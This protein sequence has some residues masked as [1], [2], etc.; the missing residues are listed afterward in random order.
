MKFIFS[1]DQALL[2]KFLDEVQGKIAEAKAGA[3]QDSARE[4]VREGRANIAAA[5]FSTRWQQGLRSQFY[6]NPGGDP[7]AVVFH[8]IGFAGVFEHGVRIGG[9]P[10]L[11]L[12]ISRNL[13]PGIK[14]PRKYGR[15][16]VSVNVTGKPPLLF[17]A[18]ERER[19]PLFVGVREV[20]IRKRWNLMRIFR[21]AAE[22]LREFYEQ[23]IKG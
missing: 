6:P 21:R 10:L 13:P 7:A 9:R 4:M 11:W 5:G 2:K 3:V 19:G 20:A 23:R 12:P 18:Q 1:A 14:S 8:R 17:D 15:K 22:R 16:L